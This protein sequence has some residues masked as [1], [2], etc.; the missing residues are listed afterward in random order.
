MRKDKCTTL[1]EKKEYIYDALQS[2][3]GNDF[4]YEPIAKKSYDTKTLDLSK[5]G[6]I[7]FNIGRN[8]I[9]IQGVNLSITP[10]YVKEYNCIDIWITRKGKCLIE[11]F[12]SEKTINELFNFIISREDKLEKL[13]NDIKL[14]NLEK[15]KNGLF[16]PCGRFTSQRDIDNDKDEF[17][18]V[19][20]G[21]NPYKLSINDFVFIK[22]VDIFLDKEQLKILCRYKKISLNELYETKETNEIIDILDA[23]TFSN[24]I[25]DEFY[26]HEIFYLINKFFSNTQ[27]NIQ[28][29]H[30]DLLKFIKQTY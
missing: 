3:M 10:Y 2:Y 20:K 8:T 17:I 27:K 9:F 30:V 21:N 23:N 11:A 26:Y 18:E 4:V 5:L 6:H 7:P 19:V 24:L 16:F 14:I 25:N 29:A 13:N 22:F 15:A 28:K 12:K 1:D